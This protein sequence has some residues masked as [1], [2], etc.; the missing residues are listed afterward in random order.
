MA[1]FE[2]LVAEFESLNA[3]VA[4]IA[5]EKRDGMFKPAKFLQR[6]PVSFPFLLD[7]DRRVTKEYGLYHRIGTDAFNIAHPAT[8]VI[9]SSKMIRYLYRGSNQLDRAPMEEVLTAVK[10]LRD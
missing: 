7:G 2:P 5:A 8:L 10:R 4:Y 1:Q 9:D 3:Q 6:N